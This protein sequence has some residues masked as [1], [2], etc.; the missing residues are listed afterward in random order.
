M[1]F[2]KKIYSKNNRKSLWC[3]F[4]R[5]KWSYI[6]FVCERVV[7]INCENEDSCVLLH[8]KF[9]F[10][11]ILIFFARFIWN[12]EIENKNKIKF[13]NSWKNCNRKYKS[14][15]NSWLIIHIFFFKQFNIKK[16]IKILCK[17]IHCK[18]HITNQNF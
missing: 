3:F 14:F 10:I 6:F 5:K 2:T 4:Q 1:S 13:W 17:F 8:G 7:L 16:F 9:K 18:K 15:H 12:I 11:F